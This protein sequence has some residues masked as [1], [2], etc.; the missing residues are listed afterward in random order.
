MSQ[1]SGVV[2]VRQHGLLEDQLQVRLPFISLSSPFL[3]QL[4]NDVYKDFVLLH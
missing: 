2:R 3:S 1:P 4:P